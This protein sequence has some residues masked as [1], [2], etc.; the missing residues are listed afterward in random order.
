M[1]DI[2]NIVIVPTYDVNTLAVVDASVYADP[3]II[4]SPYLRI[5]I[6]G[7]NTVDIPFTIQSTNILNSTSLGITTSGNEEP[8]PDGTYCVTYVINFVEQLSKTFLRVDKLQEKFDEAFMKLD[9]MEC[10]RAI[11]AQSKIELNTIYFFIQGAI[12]S[13]NNC[14]TVQSE[15][16]YIRANAMLETFINKDCGCTGTNFVINFQ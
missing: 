9:M 2:L 4:I 3:G 11:K 1:A 14:A 7:F 12:A 5:N 10:D 8:L 15:T 16:L 6:P 13:S